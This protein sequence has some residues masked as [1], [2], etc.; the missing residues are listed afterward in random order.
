MPRTAVHHNATPATDANRITNIHMPK[1]PENHS[2]N[3]NKKT[4]F[5]HSTPKQITA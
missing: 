1:N 5:R 4:K 2:K 3:K